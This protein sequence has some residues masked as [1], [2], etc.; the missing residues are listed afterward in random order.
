MQFQLVY[1]VTIKLVQETVLKKYFHFKYLNMSKLSFLLSFILLSFISFAN[2]IDD[3]WKALENHDSVK[4]RRLVEKAL[5]NPST[6][7]DALM[8]SILLNSGEE[9]PNDAK[10]IAKAFKSLKNASEYA[11]PIWYFDAL[12]GGFGEKDKK[13]LSRFNGWIKEQKLNGSLVAELQELIA[14]HYL[15]LNSFSKA[16]KYYAMPGSIMNWALTGTFENSSGSGFDKEYAPVA[17]PKDN[18][19]FKSKVNADIHW[20]TPKAIGHGPWVNLYRHLSTSTG[21]A[22]AQSFVESPSKQDVILS[23][24]FTGSM[25]VWLN[26]QLVLSEEDELNTGMDYMKRKIKLNKG[27][28]RILVQIGYTAKTSSPEFCVRLL[29]DK[30]YPIDDLTSSAAYK[31]YAKGSKMDVGASIPHFSE[32]FFEQ[33]IK[34]EPKNIIN[35]LLLAKVYSRSGKF[36][37]ANSV[38]KLAQ[39]VYPKN[40]LI[41]LAL[42]QNYSSLNDRTEL[43]RQIDEFRKYDED[44]I[45]FVFYDFTKEME[46]KNYSKAKELLD[47][48]KE[49]VGEDNAQYLEN[50]IKWEAAKEKYED[51]MNTVEYGYKKNPLE[52]YFVSLKYRVL[53]DVGQGNGAEISFLE[54]Y[55]NKHYNKR[56]LNVLLDAYLEKGSSYKF[57]KK[58]KKYIKNFPYETGFKT[59]LESYYY[60][61]KEYKKALK[62]ADRV[63]E[64]VPFSA[65]YW[66]DKSTI[67]E[68]LK[69]EDKAKDALIKTIMF[70]PNQ[71]DAREKLREKQNKKPLLSY[72]SKEKEYK[73]IEKQLQTPSTSDENYEYLFDEKNTVVFPEGTHMEYSFLAVR[74]LNQAGVD[75][76]KEASIGI[77]S[78]RQNLIVV[79]A[80]VIKKNGQKIEAETNYN[81]FVFPSLEVGDAVYLEYR[82]ET[83]TSGKLRKEFWDEDVLNGW[84]PY[85]NVSYRLF[86]PKG[87][88]LNIKEMNMEKKVNKSSID[89]FDIYEIVLKNPEKLKDEPYMPTGLEV[90]KS[91]Y[92]STIDS[93]STISDWYKDLALPRTKDNYNIDE[94]YDEIFK[95]KKMASDVDKAEAIYEYLG[96]NIKYSSISFRQS[97]YVPQKPMKT[98]STQLGDCKDLSTLYHTLAKKAG[99]KTHLVLVNTRDNG[100]DNMKVPSIGFN[101]CI[102]KIDLPKGPLYQEL[103]DNK[104]PFGYVPNNLDNSQALVIPNSNNEQ[105]GKKLVHIVDNTGKKDKLIRNTTVEVKGDDLKMSSELQVIGAASGGYRRH[106]AGLNKEK[107]KEEVAYSFSS[108]LDKNVK[109]RDYSFN[110]LEGR[111][112]VFLMK[113]KLDVENG[114]L[115]V[116]SIKAIKPAFLDVIVRLKKFPDEE[117]VTP[118]KYWMYENIDYYESN[119][120]IK[121]DD[122]KIMELPEEVSIHSPFIDYKIKV[123]KVSP[124]V[125]KVSRI[126][127]THTEKDIMP[128]QYMAFRDTVKKITKA[129][130]SFLVVK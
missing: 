40:Y 34:T 125:V 39:K 122:K 104:L 10:S 2:P 5:K 85:R 54:N 77:N 93:W 119:V 8:I 94:V 95:G 82:L 111:D 128:E 75:R 3:I 36:D 97:N 110:D 58:L 25:K 127:T 61:K 9:K 60:S 120:T 35:H 1:F 53:K 126:V 55:V 22:Y 118:L 14:V 84:V 24:G 11:Y 52:P 20:F 72:F 83:Y 26:D 18:A 92:V 64:D 116:G 45:F 105:V 71:F 80:E 99:L 123:T 68:F 70:N 89:D 100:E 107:T 21:M 47:K 37:K 98:I 50:K 101:H 42:V 6:K 41:N 124:S 96:D 67:Y 121:L 73:N 56:L 23:I 16:N 15:R 129:E 46:N 87:Y 44:N 115:S 78:Y 48:Q 113:A 74:I 43:V 109:V 108:I 63:L 130:E 12:T 27:T 4:A 76:W 91:V 19:S 69:Q 13:T 59:K 88:H 81:Q 112:E 102:I 32:A 38:L 51:L 86:V 103:T 31:S 65:R 17:H 28:N 30:W 29:D 49:F 33:K 117:R 79:K 7:T 57:E 90:G 114:V 106:Y 66:E 62:I